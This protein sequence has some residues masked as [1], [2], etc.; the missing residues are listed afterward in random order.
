MW[1]QPLEIPTNI[2][3]D[4]HLFHPSPVTS[5]SISSGRRS[6]VQVPSCAASLHTVQV[7]FLQTHVKTL[8]P[9]VFGIRNLAH[10]WP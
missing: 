7:L 5:A 4:R 9:Q 6:F 1:L 10:C 2:E 3:H 8:G